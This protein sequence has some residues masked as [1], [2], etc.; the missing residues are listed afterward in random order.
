MRAACEH[1]IQLFRLGTGNRTRL[2]IPDELCETQD[3]IEGSA[4]LV[5]HVPQEFRLCSICLLRI[6]LGLLK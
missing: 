2:L 3:M 4:E 5:T 6:V 1:I